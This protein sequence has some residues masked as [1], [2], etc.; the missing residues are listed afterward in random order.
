MRRSR[1]LS[2]AIAVAVTAAAIV[3]SIVGSSP[4]VDHAAVARM[5]RMLATVP[6]RGTVLGKPKAPVTVFEFADLQ[7]PY[8]ARYMQTLFPRLLADDVVPGKVNMVLDTVWLLGDGSRWAAHAAA[9]AAAQNKMWNFADAFYY[10]QGAEGSGYV[11]PGFIREIGSA[12]PGLNVNK[13]LVDSSSPATVT[14]LKAMHAFAL[15][16][17]VV[18]TPTFLVERADGRSELVVGSGKLEAAIDRALAGSGRK[19]G[20]SQNVE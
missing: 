7:C 20:T 13:M 12:V 18:A 1:L 17:E 6:Q 2:V 4:S 11:T 14:L 10:N 9:A 16:Q 3:L 8:C 5:Q 19:S 15:N